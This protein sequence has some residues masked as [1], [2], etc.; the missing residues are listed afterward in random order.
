MIW[1]ATPTLFWPM[2][3]DLYAAGTGSR[4]L[5]E[6]AARSLAAKWIACDWVRAAFIGV[7]FVCSVRAISTSHRAFEAGGGDAY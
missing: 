4:P 1:V 6:D 7:G 5:T 2:I 3:R